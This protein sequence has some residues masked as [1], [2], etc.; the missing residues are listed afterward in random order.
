MT[1]R[2]CDFFVNFSEFALL[3]EKYFLILKRLTPID[4]FGDMR[5]LITI[6]NLKFIFLT[7]TALCG[8]GVVVDESWAQ[9][10]L[11]SHPD[12][13]SVQTSSSLFRQDSDT[14]SIEI[15]YRVGS[16]RYEPSF[17]SNG[18]RISRFVKEYGSLAGTLEG[19]TPVTVFSASASPEGGAAW[20][21][22]LSRKR[23]LSSRRA[24]VSAGLA[25]EV[26]APANLIPGMVGVFPEDEF[27]DRVRSSS[28]ENP[29]KSWILTVLADSSATYSEK[30]QT[31]IGKDGGQCWRALSAECLPPMRSFIA[32][33]GFAERDDISGAASFLKLRALPEAGTIPFAVNDSLPAVPV[34]GEGM[35]HK[36]EIKT[37]VLGL[38]L[39][40]ANLGVEFG[41]SR[42]LSIH[43][44][45]Y[46]SGVNYFS[47]RV[48]FRTLALQPELRWNFSRAEGLFI[49]A[50][51]TAAFFNV[52]VGGDYRYQDR[53]GDTPLVGGGLS[54]GYK[55]RFADNPHWGVEFVIGAGGY[56]ISYDRFVNEANGPYVDTVDRTYIGPDN[57][58]ISV[59]YEFDLGRGRRR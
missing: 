59:F 47:E 19:R 1:L 57:A 58:A 41:L 53:T 3:L 26:F 5:K 27:V 39:L 9:S 52:A 44:P 28:L 12:T 6:E 40:M 51:A 38:G 22:Y 7:L 18:E 30:I 8:G 45:V 17:R 35:R 16:T 32:R 25:P 33:T 15:Y 2:E 24:L 55:L 54:L 46:Y 4:V 34:R 37:N 14:L 13:L 49:G 20:N 56:K 43:I 31:L 50:H 21:D 23:F 36:L 11:S 29:M 42:H 10:S 48:K